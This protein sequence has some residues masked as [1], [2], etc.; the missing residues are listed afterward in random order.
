MRI[1][2]HS[3]LLAL[4]LCFACTRSEPTPDVRALCRG[5]DDPATR[6]ATI[7][8]IAG[9][10]TRMV[11]HGQTDESRAAARDFTHAVAPRLVATYRLTR[12]S[13][14][15]ALATLHTLGQFHD[16][17]ALPAF[18]EACATE[19]PGGEWQVLEATR[20]IRE[21][22]IIRDE[23][24]PHIAR[25]LRAA[26]D[27]LRGDQPGDASRPS[28]EEIQREI[29][30]TLAHL[31]PAGTAEVAS[32]YRTDLAHAS[33]D[34]IRRLALHLSYQAGEAEIPALIRGLFPRPSCILRPA[35]A[36][37]AETATPPAI[38]ATSLP[39]PSPLSGENRGA[40]ATPPWR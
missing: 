36:S 23:Q 27:R 2:I 40:Q 20:A 28:D 39:P 29:L 19:R 37:T 32:I 31:G 8:Q 26:F 12:D 3:I 9:A 35:M 13:P 6:A 33:P 34:F 10:Y 14:S 24:K 5:L 18:I 1:A 15:D 4:A 7:R 21:V 22:D 16:S 30:E 11:R 38:V 17:K 25:A